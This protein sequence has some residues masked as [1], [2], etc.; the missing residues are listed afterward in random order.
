MWKFRTNILSPLRPNFNFYAILYL[1]QYIFQTN[2]STEEKRRKFLNSLKLIRI[3]FCFKILWTLT[4]LSLC[5]IVD[6]IDLEAEAEDLNLKCVFRSNVLSLYK[7]YVWYVR[8]HFHSSTICLSYVVN[9]E[10]MLKTISSH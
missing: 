3:Q 7:W 10:N 1:D 8:H 9:F 6:K 2:P 4:F 5:F